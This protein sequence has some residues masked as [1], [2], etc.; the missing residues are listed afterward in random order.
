MQEPIQLA[1]P[2]VRASLRADVT[3]GSRVVSV[4]GGSPVRVQSMTNTDTE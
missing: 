4:G 1:S 2:S 3:W